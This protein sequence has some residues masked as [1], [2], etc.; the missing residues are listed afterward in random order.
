M[1]SVEL[2]LDG[3]LRV[4]LLFDQFPDSWDVEFGLNGA[5]DLEDVATVSHLVVCILHNTVGQDGLP[6]N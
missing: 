5:E 2:A 3:V 4:D 1:P 6:T